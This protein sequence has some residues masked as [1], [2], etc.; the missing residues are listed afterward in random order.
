MEAERLSQLISMYGE[1]KQFLP[2]EWN[3]RTHTQTT[4][5][6]L[7]IYDAVDFVPSLTSKKSRVKEGI[8]VFSTPVHRWMQVRSIGRSLA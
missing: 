3:E 6:D 8:L 2:A 5:K 7:M 4:F 1:H